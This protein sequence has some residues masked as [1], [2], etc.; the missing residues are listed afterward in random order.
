[1]GI[2]EFFLFVLFTNFSFFHRMARRWLPLNVPTIL[3]NS[4]SLIHWKSVSFKNKHQRS[5]K[6]LL[7]NICWPF[8]L[9]YQNIHF[10]ISEPQ[11][12]KIHWLQ[13][14]LWD[15]GQ[16]VSLFFSHLFLLFFFASRFQLNVCRSPPSWDLVIWLFYI[17]TYIFYHGPF[18][19]NNFKLQ[20]WS[21]IWQIRFTLL[22]LVCVI[23]START[24]LTSHSV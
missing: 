18:S 3:M 21:I 10:R 2:W 7:L 9:C 23:L 22:C 6:I 4:A 5:A 15:V 11:F 16:F 12:T 13:K 17:F 24:P 14:A 1:M 20:T 8:F 19:F